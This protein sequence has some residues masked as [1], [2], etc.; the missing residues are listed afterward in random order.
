M[1]KYFS[2]SAFA[3][4]M[5]CFSVAFSSCKDDKSP[6]VGTWEY[7]GWFMLEEYPDRFREK[8]EYDSII[9]L[10][11]SNGSG[12]Y[13]FD[14]GIDGSGELVFTW[15]VSGNVLTMKADVNG[16]TRTDSSKFELKDGKLYL[17]EEDGDI[18]VYVRK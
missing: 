4:L 3:F 1:K 6:L 7:T 11:S 5:L 16:E 10:L 12:V 18:D 17:Y 13:T 2:I 8:S 9:I 15:S 14:H